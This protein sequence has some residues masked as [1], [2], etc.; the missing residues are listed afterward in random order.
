[1]ENLGIDY[2]LLIA[3]IINFGLLFFIFNKLV[4]KPFLKY[5]QE[6]KKKDIDRDVI[7]AELQTKKERMIEEERAWR[8]KLRDEQEKLLQT[9]K[10][11][12]EEKKTEI[13]EDAK[14]EAASIISKAHE[15]VKEEKTRF[16]REVK[17][18]ISDVSIAMIEGALRKH[19]TSDVQKKLTEYVL[20]SVKND[21]SKYD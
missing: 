6:E 9:A 7:T 3:Q 12:A 14:S 10:K 21:K 1:M 18:H 17:T 13:L 15:Q 11:I 5:L 20:S 16:Y 2:K 8:K 19:L 4:V